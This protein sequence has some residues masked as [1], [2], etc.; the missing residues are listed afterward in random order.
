M[1]RT[2]A[3]PIALPRVALY[4]RYSSENQR[5]ASI[6]DQIRICRACA[7]R[8][9]WSVVAIYTD[10]AVSGASRQR[11]DYQ[12]LLADARRGVFDMVLAEALDRLSRDQE[13]IAGFYKQLAFQSI[14][15]VTLAEGEVN[16][17]HVGLKGTMNALFLK[18]LAAKT[19]RGLEGRVRQGRS[20][21]GRCY[22]YE[23]AKEVDASGE[24]INGGRRI[25]ATEADIVRRIFREAATGI[26]P[27]A[28]A[29]RLN[30]EGI[31]GP[32][33]RPW[34][35]TTI[36]GHAARGTGILRNELYV[37]RLVWNRQRY[38]K[39]LTSGKR[40]A[41]INPAH[42]WIVHAVPELRIIDDELWQAVAARL[43]GIRSSLAVQKA[44]ATR[45]W[46][47]RRPRHLLTGLIF[48]GACGAPLASVGKDYLGCSN[49]RRS[50][51]CT[52]K[53]N[54]RRSKVE[55]IILDAL[56]RELMHPDLVAEFA[57]TFQAEVN[58]QGRLR[59]TLLVARR[60]ELD[61]VRRKL[62]GLVEA[63]ANGLR[64]T[65]LQAKLD[66]LEGEKANLEAELSGAI[67]PTLRIHPNLAELYRRKVAAL[68][69]ALVDS[70]TRD[71]ALQIL[72]GL[73][74]RVNVTPCDKGIEI[75]LTGEIAQMVALGLEGTARNGKGAPGG[76]PL[77]AELTRS[78]K[79]VAGKRNQR[80]LQRL[81]SR[82][83]VLQRQRT[84][85]S[86]V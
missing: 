32:D 65:S 66:A 36:R 47:Q 27:R 15:L 33:G 40:L 81:V 19:W 64:N 76:A 49:A 13:D 31:P 57:R 59:Q 29:R 46:E 24:K 82:I 61:D 48:C 50:G 11:P 6:E 18:D 3:S 35:D 71:E 52:N 34:G 60:R 17:L 43:S 56:K 75:E 74:E 58:R 21:G 38:V 73:V 5:D 78:V 77:S 8:E 7:E 14:K 63:I 85:D 30:Q 9:G 23:V 45:F 83:P 37:G 28:T 12:R 62:D 86:G 72:R 70:A 84:S 41:R 39:D 51:R 2:A 79:V 1:S 20:G 10:A 54:L 42:K 67:E 53:S 68:Q 22:G 44:I 26:S 69:D 55:V 25:N 16:E 80:C 4:A